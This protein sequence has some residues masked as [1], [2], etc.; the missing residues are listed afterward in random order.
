MNQGFGYE[1]IHDPQ[2]RTTDPPSS[3]AISG[4]TNPVYELSTEQPQPE[5]VNPQ[6]SSAGSPSAEI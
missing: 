5:S 4:I 3:D 6:T 2:L 1:R